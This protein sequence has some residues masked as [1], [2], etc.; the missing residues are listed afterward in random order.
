MSHAPVYENIL[1][2]IGQTPIVRLNRF[3][4]ECP[5]EIWAKCEFMNPGGSV[6][7]RIGHRMLEAAEREGRIKP[8]DILVEPTSGNTGIGI[9]LAAAVK[10]YQCII[11][12]P[13]K[14]SREK[15]VMLQALGAQIVRTRTEAGHDEE[16]SLFGVAKAIAAKLPNA[17]ILDQYCN[18]NNPDAHFFGTAE[19]ILEQTQGGKFNYF[20]CGVGTGGTITGCAR[21]FKQDAPHV[22]I[23]GADPIGSILG[24]GE[25]GPYQVEGIGYDFFPDVLDNALVDRYEKISDQESFDFARRLVRDEGLLVGGSCGTAMAAA[26]RTAQAAQPGEKVV[27][28][29]PDSSRNYMSKHLCDNWMREYG[30]DPGPKPHYIDW[31]SV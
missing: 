25:K 16:D 9:A 3:S 4:A 14:M 20:V 12:M 7:D 30:F 18:P 26:Y 28:I 11:V 10:G 8:G 2:A 29:L 5:A 13:K 23:V 1:Q 22:K 6:K 21:R 27:V 15:E 24:G 17:V 19:E 31:P